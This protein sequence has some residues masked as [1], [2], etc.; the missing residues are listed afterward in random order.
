MKIVDGLTRGGGQ[1]ASHSAPQS[2]GSHGLHHP[3]EGGVPEPRGIGEGPR[4]PL[5]HLRRRGA[6]GAQ[7]GRP[8]RRRDGRQYR[9]RPRPW[10]ATRADTALSSSSPKPRARRRRTCCACAVRPSRR[11]RPL[12]TA[13]PGNYVRVSER[14]AQEL[15]ATE[16]NGVLWANQWD[17]TA[18]RDAHVLGTGPEIWGADRRAGWTGSCARSAPAALSPGSAWP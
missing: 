6:R 17:N 5:H 7:A 2:V 14:R 18:N 15:A 10:S 16:P 9:H 8:H 4:R 13:T 11:S 12:P 3:R 1:H